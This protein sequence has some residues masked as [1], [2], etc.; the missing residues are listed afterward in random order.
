MIHP[1]RPLPENPGLS[2]PWGRREIQDA[3][4][5][6][7]CLLPRNSAGMPSACCFSN[8]KNQAKLWEIAFSGWWLG[9]KP[10][11]KYDFVNWMIIATQYSWENKIDGNQ[12]TNQIWFF[13]QHSWI[14]FWGVV[15]VYM[16]FLYVYMFSVIWGVPKIEVWTP[17]MEGMSPRVY[18]VATAKLVVSQDR[19]SSQV[20]LWC[21]NM[22]IEH[23]R[24]LNE[25]SKMA[26]YGGVF[27]KKKRCVARNWSSFSIFPTN[28]ASSYW[29]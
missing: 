8:F 4:S 21:F 28:K 7:G 2:N 15:P 24:W 11:E 9:K 23:P 10:S 25:V 17:P 27:L 22:A 16:S 1:W 12:T 18:G 20:T 13:K 26:S 14:F 29:D 19:A 6:R 5:Q 3:Q